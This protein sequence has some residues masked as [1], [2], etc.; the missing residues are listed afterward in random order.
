MEFRQQP[1]LIYPSETY[2]ALQSILFK[3]NTITDG[4]ATLNNG[5]LTGLLLPTNPSDAVNKEYVDTF[6]GAPSDPIGGIQFNNDG[7]FG[8]T[9]NLL[10]TSET[11]QLNIY[12]TLSATSI[13]VSSFSSDILVTSSIETSTIISTTLTTTNLSSSTIVSDSLSS[14]LINATTIT[15]GPI[16]INNGF[17]IGLTDLTLSDPGSAVANKNYVDSKIGSNPTGP[18][19]SLQFNGSGIFEGAPNL[20]W[21]TATNNLSITGSFNVSD[22]VLFTDITQ[23]TSP[24]SGS[25]IVSGGV[26]IGLDTHIQGICSATDF[27]ATSDITL[28][29]N[30]EELEDSMS[31][32]NKIKCYSFNFKGS[33]DKHFGLIAQQLEEIGLDNVVKHYDNHKTV[34]YIQFIAV[35]INAVKELNEELKIVKRTI[36]KEI[37]P[38][39]YK[40]TKNK[41][42]IPEKIKEEKILVSERKTFKGIEYKYCSSCK[43]WKIIDIFEKDLT[44]IDNLRMFCNNCLYH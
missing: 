33:T 7:A 30:I 41:E 12:G 13:T 34:N 26:G 37:V 39:I 8:A 9:S 43:I 31:V 14:L 32:L 15:V 17:I 44:T 10:W 24:F 21:T 23:S 3:S 36:N 4:I 1:L 27:Y 19:G 42:F 6:A 16:I 38:N 35:L 11:N 20:I 29:R 25:L 22:K 2:D 28:K 40:E 5:T 18:S